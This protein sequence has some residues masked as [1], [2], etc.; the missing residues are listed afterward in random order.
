MLFSV[1]FT[2][3]CFQQEFETGG[4]TVTVYNY[5]SGS[6]FAMI[7]VSVVRTHLVAIMQ[8][9]HTCRHF[10]TGKNKGF[11]FLDILGYLTH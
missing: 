8:L 11:P 1:T 9:I 2:I 10:D 3:L 5:N 6:L 4:S 7:I